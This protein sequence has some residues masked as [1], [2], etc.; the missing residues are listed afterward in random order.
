MASGLILKNS[1]NLFEEFTLYGHVKET[2]IFKILTFIILA[3][4]V[5]I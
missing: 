5:C 3:A 4:D 1:Q 2:G